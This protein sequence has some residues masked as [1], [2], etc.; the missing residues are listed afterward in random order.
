MHIEIN[1]KQYYIHITFELIA[2]LIVVPIL[3]TYLITKW[4]TISQFYSFFFISVILLTLIV[5]GYLLFKWLVKL[6]R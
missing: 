6:S 3:L 1:K 4:K 2:I 5:D